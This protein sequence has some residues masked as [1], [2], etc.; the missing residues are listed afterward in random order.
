MSL[1]ENA[2][3]IRIKNIADEIKKSP[4][5]PQGV[6]YPI[7]EYDFD[8][9]IELQNILESMWNKLGKEEMKA[10]TTIITIAAFKNRNKSEEI[11]LSY[12]NYQF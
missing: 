9:P 8:S 5:H 7:M 12:V 11:E 10:F 6:L 3:M 2:D 4:S 1:I